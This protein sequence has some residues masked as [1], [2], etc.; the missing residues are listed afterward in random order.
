MLGFVVGDGD[1]GF[2]IGFA[3]IGFKEEGLDDG[4]KVVGFDVLG[5]EDE[6]LDDGFII[7]GGNSILLSTN[8]VGVTVG[9]DDGVRVVGNAVNGLE[10]GNLVGD[11]VG[12]EVGTVV[13]G[14]EEVGRIDV[15]S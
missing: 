2:I 13:D 9:L 12:L 8:T 5:F 4:F 7:G 1:V 3:V 10:V 11:R 6:G 15:G 14:L